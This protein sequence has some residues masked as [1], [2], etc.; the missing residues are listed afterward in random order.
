MIPVMSMQIPET[1]SASRTDS[2]SERFPR[3]ESEKELVRRTVA[4]SPWHSD[5]AESAV[6]IVTELETP[7]GI[8]DIAFFRLRKDWKKHAVIGEI[9]SRWAYA[10]H[11]IPYRRLFSTDDF[12]YLAGTSSRRAKL[13][14]RS[15]CE[16]GLCRSAAD[17]QSWFKIRQPL[18]AL[19]NLISVEAK[20]RDWNRALDQATRY[21]AYSDQSWVLL[22]G[23]SV[24]A[25]IDKVSKFE[26]RN[27]G[28]ASISTTG[29]LEHHFSPGRS[30]A[31]REH[32]RWVVNSELLK[33]IAY[34]K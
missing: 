18:P 26:Q 6:G 17:G 15:Y 1:K 8:V 20:L 4:Q 5:P 19:A 21:L 22:D 31:I 16:L 24:G 33:R 14:L 3:F 2:A 32:D 12:T 27:V 28:L 11:E 9:P 23:R 29:E 30:R 13:A 7:N 25:A 10:F 34:A